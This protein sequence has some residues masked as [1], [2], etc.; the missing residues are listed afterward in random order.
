MKNEKK[1]RKGTGIRLWVIVTALVVALLG[2]TTV[3]ANT[4]Y[5]SI[6]STVL[7]GPAPIQDTS[8][9]AAYT[10]DYKSKAEATEAGNRLN[11]QIEE[12]ALCCW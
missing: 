3:L 1:I 11:V 4:T 5:E 10:S 8:V 9:K 7:G 2:M 12:E 6:L